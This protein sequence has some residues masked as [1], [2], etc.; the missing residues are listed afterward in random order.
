M[1][2]RRR[3]IA[4]EDEMRGDPRK[5]E[6][7]ERTKQVASVDGAKT[8]GQ[9]EVVDDASPEVIGHIEAVR[10]CDGETFKAKQ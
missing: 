10:R 2:F 8:V 9:D 1:F 7:R 4:G 3:A 6:W 5:I